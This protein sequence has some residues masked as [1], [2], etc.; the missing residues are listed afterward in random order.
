LFA[1]DHILWWRLC[2]ALVAGL[3]AGQVA[4][5]QDQTPASGPGLGL[6][7]A[8]VAAGNGYGLRY[9]AGFLCTVGKHALRASVL[10]QGRKKNFSGVSLRWDYKLLSRDHKH[11]LELLTFAS[12]TYNFSA[13]LSGRLLERETL[14]NGAAGF[15]ATDY[16]FRSFEIAGGICLSWHLHR[17]LQ[18]LNAAGLGAYRTQNYPGNLYY[19]PAGAGPLIR[20]ELILA[21]IP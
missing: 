20:T 2:L 18:W 5:A 17:R 3:F 13:Y 7:V 12:G 16:S 1:I 6:A 9:E 21:L 11:P 14:V 10:A 4:A 15:D 19:N 8:G